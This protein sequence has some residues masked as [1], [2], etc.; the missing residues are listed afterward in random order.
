MGLDAV[1]VVL[2]SVDHEGLD[3]GG[4][5]AVAAALGA[6]VCWF[7]HGFSPSFCAARFAALRS[8]FACAIAFRSS[9]ALV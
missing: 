1:A 2:A 6:G 3:V 8:R 4:G 5:N 7:A 9:S